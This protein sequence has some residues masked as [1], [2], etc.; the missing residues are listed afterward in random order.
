MLSYA[1]AGYAYR[2]YVNVEINGENIN[3]YL[4][5][6]SYQKY[7]EGSLLLDYLKKTSHNGEVNIYK[8]IRTVNLT[9]FN[10]DFTLN[11][12]EFVLNLNQDIGIEIV[13]VLLYN[14]DER[15]IKIN[16][17]EF[18]LLKF[19]KPIVEDIYDEKISENCSYIL[20]SWNESS[21]LKKKKNEMISE[22]LLFQKDIINFSKNL[23]KYIS[24]KKQALLPEKVLLINYCSVL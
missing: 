2:F 18:D 23:N 24:S 15:L 10:V 16:K 6:G 20:L 14:G 4:Y 22:L 5:H 1:D 7:E 3:G 9:Y 8:E 13:E 21:N 12:S 11:N 17:E 19:T